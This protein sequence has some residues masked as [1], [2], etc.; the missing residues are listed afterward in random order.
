MLWFTQ[1]TKN[2]ISSIF[3]DNRRNGETASKACIL[4]INNI[5]IFYSQNPENGKP[6]VEYVERKKK[7]AS[8]KCGLD[9]KIEEVRSNAFF[10]RSFDVIFPLRRR[11]R[12]RRRRSRDQ[13]HVTH[14]K[15]FQLCDFKTRDFLRVI[16]RM[17]TQRVICCVWFAACDFSHGICPTWFVGCDLLPPLFDHPTAQW[18][19][20]RVLEV[21]TNP[22]LA[23]TTGDI[24]V[25]FDI[26]PWTRDNK[27]PVAQ[28]HQM[29]RSSLAPLN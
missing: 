19:H 13:G 23:M 6:R 22:G 15:W 29:F 25:I 7:E 28:R 5:L 21:G 12:S 16:C 2:V 10:R 14:W 27:E 26:P 20:G 24:R 4:V 1:P 8:L 18:E 3:L 11:F 9:S 17:C